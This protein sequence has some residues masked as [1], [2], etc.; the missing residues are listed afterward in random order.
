MRN[1]LLAIVVLSLSIAPAI[2]RTALEL[3]QQLDRAVGDRAWGEAIAIVDELMAAEP[4]RWAELQAYRDRLEQLAAATPTPV[5][6][7]A[8]TPSPQ[9]L[10]ANVERIEAAELDLGSI[11]IRRVRVVATGPPPPFAGRPRRNTFRLGSS[12]GI[13]ARPSARQYN[14][15]FPSEY[16]ASVMV[17]APRGT[18]DVVLEAT[19]RS[20][21]GRSQTRRARLGDRD[22]STLTFTFSAA[23]VS[24]PV[25]LEIAVPAA[26]LTRS[27]R[28]DVPSRDEPIRL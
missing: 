27:F 9:I 24:A 13:P 16:T 22:R 15:T 28:L 8:E 1:L 2:A 19:L 21:T 5:P 18:E 23:A 3:H 14:T 6:E 7:P 10:R 4:E 11:Q 17:V 20:A 25:R 12:S 26:N